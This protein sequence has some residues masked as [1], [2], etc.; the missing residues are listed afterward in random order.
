MDHCSASPELVAP[1]TLAL[2]A[3]VKKTQIQRLNA[4][5]KRLMEKISANSSFIAGHRSQLDCTPKDADKIANFLADKPQ[6]PLTSYVDSL[7]KNTSL[8]GGSSNGYDDSSESEPETDDE[9][10]QGRQQKK[11]RQKKRTRDAED[12]EGMTQEDINDLGGNG[13]NG[14]VVGELDFSDD[15]G[16]EEEAPKKRKRGGKAHAH[17]K[18]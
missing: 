11:R 13:D 7:P 9:D 17:K 12:E 15:D 5:A 16:E 4:T 2:K 1:T 14:D 6:T 3:L 18:K 8:L 10:D